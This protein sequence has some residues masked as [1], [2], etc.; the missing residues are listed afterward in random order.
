MNN[1]ATLR[2]GPLTNENIEAVI[3]IH[4]AEMGYTLNSL[5]GRGHL[6]HLY[7]SMAGDPSCFVG[8][9]L[10]GDRPVGVVSGSVDAGGLT[11]RL[12]RTMS[13]RRLGTVGLEMLLHP[14]M[15]RLWFQGIRIAGPVR[16]NSREVKAVLT[17]IVVDSAAQGKGI[18]RALLEAFEGFLRQGGIG[19]YRLDTRSSNERAIR[20]YRRLGFE[21]AARRAHSIVYVR[22][23]P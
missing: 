12:I 13:W 7:R 21:E 14:Q 19:A 5:L 1:G 11:S 3:R 22:R 4:M 15:I 6:R 2:I 16:I 9:A 23:L 17:A 18:G 20:F 10:L 8:V